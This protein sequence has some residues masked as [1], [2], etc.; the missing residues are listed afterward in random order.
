MQLIQLEDMFPEVPFLTLQQMY[1]DCE[2]DTDRMLDVLTGAA[3]MGHPG[4]G[5]MCSTAGAGAA[6][7]SADDQLNLERLKVLM[8]SKIKN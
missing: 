8:T 2:N 7:L 1:D 5:G 4:S 3:G 6:A